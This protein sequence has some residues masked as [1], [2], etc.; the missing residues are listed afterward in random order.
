M[1]TAGRLRKVLSY[2]PETG[3]F[4]RNSTGKVV[5][6]LRH[7]GYVDIMV[8]YRSYGAHRLAVLYMTGYWPERQVNHRNLIRSDNRWENI[9]PATR[10]QNLYNQGPRGKSDIKGVRQRKNGSWEARITSNYET[11]YLGVFK[12]SGDAAATYRKAAEELHGEFAFH[13][14]TEN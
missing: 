5:G 13:L 11:K 10:Q 4:T 3:V 12:T 6:C 8:D 14:V 7:K 1:L 9:R 2:D